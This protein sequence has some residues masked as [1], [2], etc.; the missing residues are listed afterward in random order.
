[1]W[2]IIWGFIVGGFNKDNPY[3]EVYEIVIPDSPTPKLMSNDEFGVWW[4]G[5]RE[6]VDRVFNAID[7]NFHAKIE[8]SLSLTD[9]QKQTIKDE[10]T[11]FALPINPRVLALQDCVKLALTMIRTTIDFQALA[12]SQR[13]VGG[14]IDIA[15]ITKEDGLHFVQR[16]KI[17]G[18]GGNDVR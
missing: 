13:G 15:T 7:A 5:Q 4:G 14:H 8:E 6:I 2:V 3:A 1:M 10:Q 12:F 16:K 18:E 11:K 17:N 9:A